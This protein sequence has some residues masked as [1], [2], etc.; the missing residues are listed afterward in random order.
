M[1]LYFELFKA[2]DAWLKLTPYERQAKTQAILRDAREHPVPGVV[3]FSFRTVDG[4]ALFDGATTQPVLPVVLDRTDRRS[5]GFQLAAAWMVPTRDLIKPLENRFKRLQ[6]VFDYFDQQNAWG[7]MN[8]A[9]TLADM[10]NANGTAPSSGFEGARAGEERKGFCW[11]PPG[12]FK[13]GVA[14]HDVT[15]TQGFWMAKYEVTQELYRSVMNENPSAFVGD[16]LPVDS[17]NREQTIQFCRRLTHR[18][19][20][21]GELPEGWE[22]NLPTEAQWE[23]AARAGTDTRFP[24]GDDERLADDYSWHMFNSGSQSHPVGTKKPNAWGLHD[25]LGNCLERL[26]DVWVDPYPAGNDPYVKP[27]D[28]QVRSD[29]SDARWG[30]SRGGGFFIP[31]IITARDRT[32]LGPGNTG[33]LLGFRIAIVRVTGEMQT[34]TVQDELLDWGI[35]TAGHWVTDLGPFDPN[36]PGGQGLHTEGSSSARWFRHENGIEGQ[37]NVGGLH[38][39]FV[40]A[41]DQESQQI[42]QHTVNSDGGAGQTTI[43]REGDHWYGVE[44]AVYP[45]GSHASS[46]DVITLSDGGKT[47]EHRITKRK[48]NDESLPEIRFVLHRV[49]N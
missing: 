16:S 37:F 12:T 10:L 33:Y 27:D 34:S 36:S 29:E 31:P 49:T 38:G 22:Y 45:D 5:T 21:S 48:R 17:V 11:C 4:A 25:M 26:R 1:Y 41:V 28:V 30:V 35:A 42:R 13:M 24:W 23:Y 19:R 44:T 32:R 40:T 15:L 39:Y 2:K 8:G 18:D 9:A 14:G 47:M 46:T 6:W 43:Y 3:P 7:E 20:S